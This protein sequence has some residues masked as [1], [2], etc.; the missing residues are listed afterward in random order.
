VGF[1]NNLARVEGVSPTGKEG[2]R[3]PRFRVLLNAELV[4]TTDE[5]AVKVRDISIGGARLEAQRAIARGR[6]VV[7][8]RGTIELFAKIRWLSGNECGVEFDDAISEAEMLAFLQEPAKPPAFIPEPFK[9]RASN[10][11]GATVEADRAV[12]EAFRSPA[13]PQCTKRATT[14]L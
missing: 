7:L 5:Q 4:T 8:R 14:S 9:I 12:V 13:S 2:R 1:A 6:D 10:G 3:N 11:G